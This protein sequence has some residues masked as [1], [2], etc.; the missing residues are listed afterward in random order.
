MDYRLAAEAGKEQAEQ[1]NTG[2]VN[3]RPRRQG[4][5]RVEIIDAPFSRI[6]AQERF[7]RMLVRRFLHFDQ[8]SA[9]TERR[10]GQA[11]FLGIILIPRSA[12]GGG[13]LLPPSSEMPLQN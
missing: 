6:S 12:M 10:K 8:V 7:G 13:T 3:C 5:G 11:I 9:S 1:F 2:G 4:G